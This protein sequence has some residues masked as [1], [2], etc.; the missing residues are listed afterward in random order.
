MTIL[1]EG[2][3]LVT[4]RLSPVRRWGRRSHGA[5]RR[6]QPRRLD[7]WNGGLRRGCPGCSGRTLD[8]SACYARG[9]GVAE[10]PEECDWRLVTA[11][12]IK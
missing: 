6:G 8:T 4:A 3:Q 9:D 1:Y 7:K 11:Y 2:G 10:G 5:V 12:S